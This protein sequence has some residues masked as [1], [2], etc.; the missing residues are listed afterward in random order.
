MNIVGYYAAWTANTGFTPGHIDVTRLTHINYAFANIGP[1]L[2]ITPG[3]PGIDPFNF[4]QLNALKRINPDLKTL[5]S[6][7]GWTWSGSFSD[8]ALTEDSRRTFADSCVAFILQYGFDGVDL[9]WEFPVSGGL[10]TNIRRSDDSR[11]FTLL[12]QSLREALDAQ[13]AADGTHYLLTI[14]G[15]SGSYYPQNTELSLIHSYLDF[16]NI[17]A[18]DIHGTWDSYTDFNAPLYM[19]NDITD[20]YKW[21]VDSAVGAWA[22]A[23]FPLE[24]LMLGIPFYGYIYG[25]VNNFNFGLYQ[26][27]HGANS[28]PYGLIAAN[29]LNSPD[30]TRYFH[31]ESRVPWLFDGSVFISYDDPES[32]LEKTNFIRENGMGGAMI[33]DLSADPEGILLYYLYDGLNRP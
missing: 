18:Y 13:E 17:M 32:I 24:K 29:Y 12:L 25:S 27:F 20:H 26:P 5:I 4:S 8:V 30:F 23:G 33:W 28:I 2:R 21:S 3:F 16:A 14:A 6:V 10:P 15:G 7:G 22:E 9:D 31:P 11:N 19:N 1:D